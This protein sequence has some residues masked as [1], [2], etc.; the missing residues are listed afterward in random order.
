MNGVRKYFLKRFSYLRSCASICGCFFFIFLLTSG[1]SRNANPPEASAPAAHEHH[2]PH[3]GTAV[4]LG[5][6]E[7]H[8]EL[9]L[10]LTTGR[11][12]AYVLDGEMENFVRIAAESFEITAQQP[13]H[14]TQLVLKAVPNRATGET[15]G[16]TSQFEAQ[17]DVLK[18]AT[19]FNATLKQLTVRG[20]VYSDV[21]FNFP[22]GDDET[23]GAA[24]HP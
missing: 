19:N 6:E 22:K 8:L 1:C 4:E 13:G 20:K 15:V 16:D 12:Q 18:S 5:N 14:E 23:A 10:D 24:R 2:T 9:V 7:Y 11:L 21:K 3:G 17:A